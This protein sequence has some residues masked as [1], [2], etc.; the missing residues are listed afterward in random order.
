MIKVI[1]FGCDMDLVKLANIDSLL[2]ES[3]NDLAWLKYL[4]PNDPTI[5][6]EIA[7]GVRGG[8][9]IVFRGSYYDY[10]G[11]YH[12]ELKKI[13]RDGIQNYEYNDLEVIDNNWVECFYTKNGDIQ[14][15][16]YVCD[17]EFG[18]TEKE[19]KEYLIEFAE[20]LWKS[21]NK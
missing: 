5:I 1:D 21:G 8:I 20:D 17:G 3:G 13:I 11:E 10:P 18:D 4:N 7:I 9:K 12:E 19:I 14:Y 15:D 2:V 16:S 6:E